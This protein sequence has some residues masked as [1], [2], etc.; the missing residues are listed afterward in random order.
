[1]IGIIRLIS[2]AFAGTT[3]EQDTL[4]PV[5]MFTAVSLLLI[6]AVVLAGGMPP[7]FEFETF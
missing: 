1:M 5:L 3:D 6:N 4:F 2:S 7:F